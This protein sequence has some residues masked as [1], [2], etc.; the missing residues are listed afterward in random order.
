MLIQKLERAE[1]QRSRR[2]IFENDER[3]LRGLTRGKHNVWEV[4]AS[5]QIGIT[6]R[7]SGRVQNDGSCILSFF[8]VLEIRSEPVELDIHMR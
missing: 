6:I 8:E 3:H 5:E 1:E 2:T 4:W 7:L